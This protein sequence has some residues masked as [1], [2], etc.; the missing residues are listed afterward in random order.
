[1]I[2]SLKTCWR[3]LTGFSELRSA[4]AEFRA[5]E[6]ISRSL[7]SKREYAANNNRVKHNAF[8]P[9]PNLEHS[10]YRTSSLDD[11]A[12]WKLGRSYVAEPRG[13]TLKGRGDLRA[14]VILDTGLTL[15]SDPAPHPLH[16]N[17]IGWPTDKH[18]QLQ[19]AVEL[20][21]AASLVVAPAEP[22]SN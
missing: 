5:S 16:A 2:Q 8:L 4:P 1:M 20:A 11:S 10:V 3:I 18:E 9:P 14:S 21:E 6:R 22:P 13:K 19:L 12:I 7:L 17:I 15:N